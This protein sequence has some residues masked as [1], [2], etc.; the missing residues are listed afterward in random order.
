MADERMGARHTGDSNTAA[1]SPRGKAH[2]LV[3]RSVAGG[4][5]GLIITG[6]T[7]LG[8]GTAG[9]EPVVV[10]DALAL[11]DAVTG[12][13]IAISPSAMSSKVHAAVLLAMPLDFAEAD[14]AKAAFEALSPVRLGTAA[15]GTSLFGGPQIATAAKPKLTD[16][17]LP[18]DKLEAVSWH[19][20]NLVSLGNGLSVQAEPAPQAPPEDPAPGSPPGSPPGPTP[21]APAPD[22]STPPS[23]PPPS[24]AQPGFLSS[25]KTVRIP[26][27]NYEAIPGSLLPWAGSQSAP[28]PSYS[29]RIEMLE[30]SLQEQRREADV[31]EAGK[32]VAM[33]AGERERGT[34]PLLVTVIAIAVTIATVVRAWVLRRG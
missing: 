20:S 4:L 22:P 3:R 33:P 14:R 9:A 27:T 6:S 11:V 24:N 12:Q 17:G 16:I 7:F 19:F 25:G 10:A 5:A 30:Q 31:R 34:V 23:I 8:A 1:D 29:P 32:A 21:P 28:P 26:P 13:E 18:P 15:E 2:P